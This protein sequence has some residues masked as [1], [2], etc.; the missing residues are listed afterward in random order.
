MT[1]SCKSIYLYIENS[2]FVHYQAMVFKNFNRIYNI[3][4]ILDS[5]YWH[6]SY[7]LYFVHFMTHVLTS[8]KTYLC[9]HINLA[10]ALM[11]QHFQVK[12]RLWYSEEKISIFYYYFSITFGLYFQGIIPIRHLLMKKLCVCLYRDLS[13]KKQVNDWAFS[14]TFT[15]FIN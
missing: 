14:I 6:C 12:L 15:S 11:E 9:Q 8:L 2:L 5:L 7:K 4:Q 3:Y 10:G 13:S 1:K